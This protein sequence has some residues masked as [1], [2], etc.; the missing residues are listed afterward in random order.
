MVLRHAPQYYVIRTLPV[1]LSHILAGHIADYNGRE[2]RNDKEV[3]KFAL[4]EIR[5]RFHFNSHVL[6]Y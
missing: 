3:R 5:I 1:L 4:R 6:F 2:H